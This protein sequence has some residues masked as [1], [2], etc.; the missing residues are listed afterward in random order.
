MDVVSAGA[1]MARAVASTYGGA[2]FYLA[3]AQVNVVS[4]GNGYVQDSLPPLS[5]THRS[6]RSPEPLVSFPGAYTGREPGILIV[7]PFVTTCSVHTN[8]DALQDI[9]N[10]PRDN[11]TYVAPGPAVWNQ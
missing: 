10:L 6:G 3:C 11:Y 1:H 8:P 9:W 5:E 7:R 4:G 2:Q